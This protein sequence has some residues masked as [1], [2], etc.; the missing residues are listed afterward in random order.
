M[1]WIAII[2][3]VTIVLILAKNESIRARFFPASS[4][5]SEVTKIESAPSDTKSKEKKAPTNTGG[6]RLGEADAAS[7][8]SLGASR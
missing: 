1:K 8:M 7:Q 5:S 4:E 6:S 2:D 3:A